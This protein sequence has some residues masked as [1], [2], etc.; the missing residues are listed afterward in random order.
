MIQPD[1]LRQYY[2]VV[3]E[4]T[5]GPFSLEELIKHPSLI[6][7][8]LVWKPGLDNWVPAKSMPEIAS[9]FSAQN[10]F[11]QFQQPVDVE[12]V[13]EEPQP[14]HTQQNSDFYRQDSYHDSPSYNQPSNQSFH[15]NQQQQH[16]H[17]H[18]QHQQHHQDYRYNNPYNQYQN[19]YRPDFRTNWL[20]WAIVATVVGF[21]TSC[22]GAI[23]GIIGIV[24]ANKANNLYAQG[25]DQEADTANSNA[26]VM[27]IIGLAFAALGLL[28]VFWA[29]SLFSAF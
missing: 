23:F 25:F 16:H 13:K 20:P 4:K 26:K 28:V 6:P 9:A 27:T 19:N 24:Q 22:I 3:D 11:N 2:I 7:D 29:G 21:F 14:T 1:N 18:Q 5:T 12:I 8:S 10:S 17:Q 15:H